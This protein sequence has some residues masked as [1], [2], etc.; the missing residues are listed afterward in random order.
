[1]PSPSD[2]AGRSTAE[3]ATSRGVPPQPLD[4]LHY[5]GNPVTATT[6]LLPDGRA[7][8]TPHRGPT[9][10]ED[11]EWVQRI[12]REHALPGMGERHPVVAVGSNADPGVLRRKLLYAQVEVSAAMFPC[13]VGGLAVGHSAH[14]SARGY[15]AAAPYRH[16]GIDSDLVAVFLTPRQIRAVDDTEPNYSRVVLERRYRWE[17]P[18]ISVRKAWIYDSRWGVL[19]DGYRPLP[20]HG[21][22]ELHQMLLAHDPGFARDYADRSPQAIVAELARA[23]AR[24]RIAR[25]WAQ[26]GLVQQSGIITA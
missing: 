20:L 18:G 26:S 25:R 8:R 6:V 17:I 4:P 23:D 5:P 15:I 14:V 7:A 12:L 1:M 16:D 11:A 9:R 19:S 2:P 22:Q 3:G 13:R 21:Q 24:D 10:T